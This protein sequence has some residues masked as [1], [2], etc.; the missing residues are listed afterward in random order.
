MDEL[1]EIKYMLNNIQ[2]KLPD[3][4]D[5]ADWSLKILK[6]MENTKFAIQN[7]I[8]QLGKGVV[9]L[10][11]TLVGEIRM[12]ENTLLKE[13]KELRRLIMEKFYIS[14]KLLDETPNSKE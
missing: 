10:K 4:M 11:K 9:D 6:E 14:S 12:L 8:I 5:L 7:D 3:P 2:K 1:D 13:I